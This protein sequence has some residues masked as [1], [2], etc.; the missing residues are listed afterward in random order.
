M[1]RPRRVEHS[2]AETSIL[3]D[4]REPVVVRAAGPIVEGHPRDPRAVSLPSYHTGAG[5]DAPQGHS[6][7]LASKRK[8]R[9]PCVWYHVFSRDSYKYA[10]REFGE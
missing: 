2:H 9:A 7:V 4:G 3:P 5:S 6:V 8:H 10:S 1:A